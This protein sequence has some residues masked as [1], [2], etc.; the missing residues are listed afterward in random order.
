MRLGLGG[1]CPD[2]PCR[3]REGRRREPSKEV[4]VGEGA[5]LLQ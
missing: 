3:L 1:A 4:E 5:P 2:H